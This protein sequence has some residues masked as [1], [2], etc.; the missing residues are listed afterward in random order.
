MIENYIDYK[1]NKINND[2]KIIES[3]KN[4]LNNNNQNKIKNIEEIISKYNVKGGTTYID[5]NENLIIREDIKND[6]NVFIRLWKSFYS[7]KNKKVLYINDNKIF[8]K[9]FNDIENNNLTT[10]SLEYFNV[11]TDEILIDLYIVIYLINECLGLNKIFNINNKELDV[12]NFFKTFKNFN[13]QN[14]KF[15][16]VLINNKE[17]FFIKLSYIIINIERINNI[18]TLL[19]FIYDIYDNYLE[20]Q[21]YKSVSKIIKNKNIKKYID[22]IN[23]ENNNMKMNMDKIDNDKINMIIKLELLDM[24]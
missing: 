6:I 20:I 13:F 23:L 19:N 3:L 15:L 5:E 17:T 2:T 24:L 21:E 16:N 7:F 11:L 1:I 12:E 4:I 9:I 22:N 14:Y 18:E 10:I 8:N